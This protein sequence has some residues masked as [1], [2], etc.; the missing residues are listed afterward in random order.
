M[1]EAE[2]TFGSMNAL[3]IALETDGPSVITAEPV[4][5]IDRIT[6]RL[7]NTAGVE[8]VDSLSSMDYVYGENGALSA[9]SLTGGDFSGRV[10]GTPL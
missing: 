7:E 2:D 9:S 4:A 1:L 5:V 3:G 8:S 6:E 10:G